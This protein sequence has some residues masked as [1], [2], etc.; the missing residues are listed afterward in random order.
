M[1]YLYL[2]CVFAVEHVHTKQHTGS[3][4]SDFIWNVHIVWWG[5]DTF[6]SFYITFPIFCP[7]TSPEYAP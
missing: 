6:Q 7:T 2:P 3:C 4:D 1:L 5:L